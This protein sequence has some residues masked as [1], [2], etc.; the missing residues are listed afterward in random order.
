MGDE[1]KLDTVYFGGGTPS[2]LGGSGV[3]ELI[4]IVSDFAT[5]NSDAEITIEAN[6]EDVSAESANAWA[7]AGINRISLGA[8]TFNPTVLSWMHRTHGADQIS[9][10][11]ANARGA[12][13]GNI[14]LDLIFAL[15]DEV[16]RAWGD[17]LD[18]ALELEPTH[19]SL[20]GLTIEPDAPLGRMTAQARV[21]ATPD[22]RYADEFLLAH[23]RL[24]SA[25]FDH[26]EVSNFAKPGFKSRHNS[27]YW[28]DAPYVGIGPSAHSFDG[29]T[30]RWNIKP[31]AEWLSAL[32][33]GLPV[34]SGEE[35]LDAQNRA[36]EKVYLGLRTDSGYVMS[37]SDRNAVEQWER[38]GWAEIDGN[39]VRL[40]PEG[41]LRLDA[42]AAGLT[43]S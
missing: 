31:Y 13:I 38:A 41:W 37:G 9:D 8:Q 21:T 32:R 27:A 16:E 7:A 40:K 25:G 28:T 42:L 18:K 23:Q 3:Q 11:V 17:D 33:S 19:V 22:D 30:R 34:V 15:P 24:S 36:T 14:S 43:G 20:Y 4:R 29:K 12:G 10:A 5:L 6:P 35:Q 2:K 1:L 26:Y 39:L